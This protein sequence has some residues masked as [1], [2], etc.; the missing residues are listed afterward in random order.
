MGDAA[1]ASAPADARP[2]WFWVGLLLAVPLAI[3]LVAVVLVESSR[4]SDAVPAGPEGT[5]YFT[6]LSQT[7][8]VDPVTYSLEPPVGGDHY[9]DW[10][11]CGIYDEPVIDE[12]VVHSMEHGAVW[13]TYPPDLPADQVKVLRDIVRAAYVGEERY[14]VLSPYTGLEGEVVASAWGVQLR[15]GAADDPRLPEFLRTFAGGPQS[16]EPLNPCR[17]KVGT[18]LD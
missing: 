18:P 17:D 2:N 7:H 15:V 13:M 12:H 14:I 6:D 3:A 4:S 16:P 10:Q 5:A 1:E 8:V 9:E 11:S